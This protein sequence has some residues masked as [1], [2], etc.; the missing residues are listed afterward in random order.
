MRYLS[1]QPINYLFPLD[2]T[3]YAVRLEYTTDLIFSFEGERVL[4][5]V[6]IL[7][8][9]EDEVKVQSVELPEEWIPTGSNILLPGGVEDVVLW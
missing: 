3:H 7:S 8:P 6:E 2:P 9:G 4:P 5:V 1:N